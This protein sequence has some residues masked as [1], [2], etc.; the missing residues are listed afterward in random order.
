MGAGAGAAPR[1]PRRSPLTKLREGVTAT[2]TLSFIILSAAVGARTG[3]GRLQARLSAQRAPRARRGLAAT[4]LTHHPASA[5]APGLYL[6]FVPLM[7]LLRPLHRR[8]YYTLTHAIVGACVARANL[9]LAVGTHFVR[10]GLR[11]AL[12]RCAAVWCTLC[13]ALPERVNGVR[14]RV[15][16]EVRRCGAC[17]AAPRWPASGGKLTLA[18]PPA[19]PPCA[20]AAAGQHAA[21]DQQPQVRPGLRVRVGGRR[22]AGRAAAGPLH[23]CGE[24]RAA[25]C[26]P[27]RLAVQV[28]VLPLP[29]ALL[30]R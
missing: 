30:G 16:G 4:R 3:G 29:G 10:R 12:R 19:A 15:T 14:V 24:G 7:L 27:L 11:R 8:L 25:A 20:A 21:A 2:L 18:S 22:A 6:G 28:R 13:L 1:A 26:A 23:G 9:R 17:L 5:H